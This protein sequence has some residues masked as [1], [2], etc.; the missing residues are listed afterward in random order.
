MN[1]IV[2]HLQSI[3]KS[4]VYYFENLAKKSWIKTNHEILSSRQVPLTPHMPNSTEDVY[5][6]VPRMPLAMSPAILGSYPSLAYLP[7]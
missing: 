6:L 1:H 7:K 4:Q 5:H 3:H 2:Y